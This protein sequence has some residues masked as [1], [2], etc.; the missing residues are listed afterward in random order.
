ME[1][2]GAMEDGS[3]YDRPLSRRQ[4]SIIVDRGCVLPERFY[5]DTE[6]Q[7]LCGNDAAKNFRGKRSRAF[8]IRSRCKREALNVGV[9]PVDTG[10]RPPESWKLT[11]IFF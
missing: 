7:L 2:S 3:G 1:G 5:P 10:K 11:V 8:Q 4:S 6:A 9:T